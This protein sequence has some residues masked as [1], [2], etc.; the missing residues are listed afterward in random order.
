MIKV[1]FAPSPTGFLHIGG[2]RTALF[3][4][5]YA[6]SQ[7]GKFVL[8]IEDTDRE[9]SKP[10]YEEEILRSMTWLGLNWDEF[11]RQSERFDIYRQYA[12]KLISEDKAYCDGPAVILKMP[13]EQ[14]KI[15]D[16]IRGEIQF[17]TETLKD[18]VLMKSDGAPTYSFACVVD[19]A[20]MEISHVV[21]GE[22][23]ISNTP[24]QII[25]YQALGFKPPK[26]AHLPLIMDPEGGRMSKR[27]GATAVSEYQKDGFLPGAIVN[28]LMLLGWS[29]GN[30][31]EIVNL[32]AAVKN[33]S[34]KKVNKA[35]AAFSMDKLLWI[36]AQYIKQ[37]PLPELT[38]ILIPV[39]R[40]KG[41]LGEAP[42]RKHL[43]GIVKLYH[44]RISTLMEFADWTAYLF[45]GEVQ[46]LPED[47][48]KYLTADKTAAFEGL[49]KRL[50]GV[51]D[52]SVA[53]TEAAFR[54]V[55]EE[56]GMKA[57]DLVHPVRVALTGKSVGPGLFETMAVLGKEKTILFLQKTFA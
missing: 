35:A 24:K 55:V 39:L 30:N 57:G 20:L 12:E 29:P 47:R 36:N 18:Q 45:T 13:L 53:N 9:R 5:M 48:Q 26:F 33:F 43:E 56:L 19:D 27:T 31:Q 11:Y 38:E 14:V 16:L 44:T 8:R 46:V 50:D 10:E 2:A 6:R 34:I 32:D 7:G 37:M 41:W 28:Y 3:N 42:D 4:W 15:F 51:A 52:F 17:D 1:R 25:I 21:R 40:E 49:A 22:D 23:H 54:G